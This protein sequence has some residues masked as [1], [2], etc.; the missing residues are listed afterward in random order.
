MIIEI[1]LA[2][3]KS[4]D[5]FL[6]DAPHIS[7]DYLIDA[8]IAEKLEKCDIQILQ[9]VNKFLGDVL[10]Y[11]KDMENKVNKDHLYSL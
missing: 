7:T 9:F 5:Y 3:N 8:Q 4:V 1:S 6:M 10:E 2:L 11:H